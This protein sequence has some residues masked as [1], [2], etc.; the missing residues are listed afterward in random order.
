[1]LLAVGAG[2]SWLRRPGP[3]VDRSADPAILAELEDRIAS[4]PSLEPDRIRVTV[5]GGVVVLHGSV[6]GMGAWSCAIRN[7]E[8]VK[9]VTTVVDN[10]VLERGPPS[11]PCRATRDPATL[12]DGP[13]RARPKIE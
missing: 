6:H 7:A 13:Y 4:E 10:L 2:C 5:D 3:A 12:R 11:T 9:G 1:M 8:L